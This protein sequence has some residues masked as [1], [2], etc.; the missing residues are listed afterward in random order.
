VFDCDGV[1]TDGTILIGADGSETKA[2]NVL[3]GSG[4]KYLQRAGLKTAILS[5]RSAD[6]VKHRAKELGISYV[7]QGCKVK[8]DDL[9]KLMRR[10]KTKLAEICY[11]GDDLPD[12]PIMRAVG[13]AVAVANAR[14][15]VRRVAHW[16][17]SSRG[18]DGAAR[19]V[20]EKILKTQDKWREIVA[21]YGIRT[22]R[23]SSR[24]T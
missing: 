15:E 8:L 9:R 21:C 10:S 7:L 18:G 2:F 17:T 22:G 11:V 13:V 1:L 23:G 4:I 20:A 14:L 16:V 6:A 5:G 19:E 3:D 12:I 24:R